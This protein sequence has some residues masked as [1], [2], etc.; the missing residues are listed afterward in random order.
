MN[1]TVVLTPLG[2]K[3]WSDK[4]KADALKAKIPMGRFAGTTDNYSCTVEKDIFREISGEIFR[5]S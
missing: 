2:K 4:Q 5:G 1:P 3:V